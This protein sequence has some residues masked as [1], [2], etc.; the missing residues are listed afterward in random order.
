[1]AKVDAELV[2]LRAW[3]QKE[4]DRLKQLRE[5][6]RGIEETQRSI[7]ELERRYNLDRV[8]ELKYERLPQLQRQLA[9]LSE[10]GDA[11]APG[12][13]RVIVDET[14][15]ADQIRHMVSRSTGIPLEKLAQSDRSRLLVLGEQLHRRVVGQEEA[16]RGIA[17]A[18]LRS[19][20][21]VANRR[22]PVCSA[23]FL[24][25]T[26]VGK[27]ELSK[28]VARELFD[29]ERHMVR[30][31]MS[32]Y[33]EQHSVAR[34]IGAPPG[35]VG[36]EDGGQL[37]EA[38][39]RRPYSVVLF[40]EV[41][42]AH[43]LVLNA[44]LQ[45]LDEGRLTDGKGRLVDFTNTVIFLTS[46]VG[47]QHLLTADVTEGVR[48]EVMGEVRRHFRPE[49]LNRLDE[50]VIFQQLS[51][52]QLHKVAV[53]LVG[54]LAGPL[55]CDEGVH[56]EVTPAAIECIVH[57][58]YEPAYGARSEA[59][60]AQRASGRVIADECGRSA[61]GGRYLNNALKSSI[62]TSL[63]EGAHGLER[64]A[65]QSRNEDIS[66]LTYLLAAGR[67]IRRYLQREVA[68]EVAR[69]LMAQDA[70]AQGDVITVDASHGELTYAITKGKRADHDAEMRA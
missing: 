56:L 8:A 14:V 2:P 46:N 16:V 57:A 38:V 25:P 41:E 58:A 1:M 47:S 12:A 69:K 49:F 64:N 22:Q 39:R 20:A 48:S 65:G 18:I 53:L 15:G 24:G 7:Q 5:V 42:K 32:E 13:R 3:H 40:D 23:L 17:N 11:P 55:E 62:R 67:P 9:Q 50:V 33:M 54:D 63:P 10:R 60:R 66:L 6:R 27:T 43:P 30:V 70:L 68:T 28:V 37:T 4:R 61:G 44:L 51:R 36:H 21:G 45:V 26:G 35:Y 34:L 52:E 31:D 59:P 19:R 29:D